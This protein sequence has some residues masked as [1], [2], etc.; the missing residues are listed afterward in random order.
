[1]LGLVAFAGWA[2]DIRSL[3]SIVP[4]LDPMVATSSLCAAIAALGFGSLNGNLPVRSPAASV[5]GAVIVVLCVLTITEYAVGHSLGIDEMI[6]AD[7]VAAIRPFPGSMTIGAALAFNA[8]G[9]ALLLLGLSVRPR[10]TQLAHG[11]AIVPVAVALLSLAGH[12]QGAGGLYRVG[13]FGIVSL[14]TALALTAL[15]AALLMTRARQGWLAAYEGRPMARS[16]LL[17]ILA[18]SMAAP[19]ATGVFVRFGTRDLPGDNL[20]SP[21]LFSIAVTALF[22]GLALRAASAVRD[23][24]GAIRD[25]AA[26]AARAA[27]LLRAVVANVGGAV[28]AKD[29]DGRYLVV[30][31]AGCRA[32]G[33]TRDEM[34][35]STDAELFPPDR[36]A[37]RRASDMIALQGT[38][39]FTLEETLMVEGQTRIYEVTKSVFR[40]ASGAIAG[41]VGVA[42]DITGRREAERRDAFLL[43]L[44]DRLRPLA[45]ANAIRQTAVEALAAEIDVGRVSY[46]E[47]DEAQNMCR[48]EWTFSAHAMPVVS[49]NYSLEGLEQVMGA[50]KAGHQ[51]IVADNWQDP[52]LAAYV[53]RPDIAAAQV[54]ALLNTP[55]IK[56]GLLV[57]ALTIHHPEPR[58]WTAWEA[59]LAR[60]VADRTWAASERA[61]A[62]AALRTSEALVRERADEIAAIYDSAPVGLCVLD[63]NLRFVRINDHL[64]NLNGVPAADHIGKTFGEVLP[65]LKGKVLEMAQRVLAGEIIEDFELSGM[66]PAHPGMTRTWRE[67]WLPLRDGAGE[68]IGITVSAEDVTEAKARALRQSLL[69]DLADRLRASPRDALASASALVGGWLGASRVG[70]A[71]A[72]HG[73]EAIALVGGFTDGI[74]NPGTALRRFD[75]FSPEV[76]AEIVAGH[77]LIVGDIA[78]DPRTA[79]MI[80]AETV[81]NAGSAVAVPLVR[82]G[83]VRASFYVYYREARSWTDEE[84]GLI[85]EIAA[86]SWAVAEQSR[87][88]L[89]LRRTRRRLDAVLNNASVAIFLTDDRQHCTYMNHAAEELTGYALAET[90]GRPLHEVV[91]HHH[92]DGRPYPIEDCPIERAFPES[93]NTRGEDVFVHKNGRF[94]PVGFVASPIRDEAARIVGTII[95]VRDI[96]AERAAQTALVALNADLELRVADALAEQRMLA[97]IVESTDVILSAIDLEFN[98][99]ARNRAYLE[100]FSRVWGIRP[101]V[102][103]NLIDLLADH[104][105]DQELV[106]TLWQR[107]LGG[108]EFTVID[109][110]GDAALHRGAYELTFRCLRD[111]HGAVAGIYQ[112][113]R[114]ISERLQAQAEL[115]TARAQLH[116][117]QKLETIGQLTGSVAHDFNNLL[118]PIFGGLDFVRR[119]V[120]G[121]ERVDRAVDGAL[122]SAE[123]ARDLIQR[124]LAFARRQTLQPRSVDVAA[125]VDGMRDLIDRSIGRNIQVRVDMPAG[126]PFAL[127]DPNQLEMAL[128][129]LCINARDAMPGGGELE[130]AAAETVAP[131][132]LP[133]GHYVRLSVTDT[134]TGMDAETLSRAVE[135]FFSTKGEGQGTGLGLS[136]VHGLAA[137]SGGLFQLSSAPGTGTI[138]ALWLP[139]SKRAAET[140]IAEGHSEP[141]RALWRACVLLV[142][143]EELVRLSTAE[144][145]RDMGYDVAEAGSADEALAKVRAGFKPEALITDH[146]MPGMS[147]VELAAQLRTTLPN[148]PVLL[149][150]GYCNLQPDE[151]DGLHVLAKP[152]RHADLLLHVARIL[153]E[154]EVVR[155][156]PKSRLGPSV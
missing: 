91:H 140:I 59:E 95:E 44:E 156:R 138:A 14:G 132:S 21:A 61:R 77:T 71:I 67:N 22:A 69:L 93:A 104:P 74:A 105:E 43:A 2:L 130:I 92:P 8:L 99:I 4:G 68:I 137:Q 107:A 88:E 76:V 143:D 46:L 75:H 102:G 135:P 19:I 142:D 152:F 144:D 38:T 6:V 37:T 53:A 125:L 94:Y 3:T 45:D 124:L 86:R 89:E 134:G 50:M 56:D 117:M 25:N 80:A 48:V 115:E 154:G 87:A 11:F 26:E 30:N 28:F 13:T 70:Y 35:G 41:I 113:A 112:F 145:L 139:V 63:T 146:M 131:Q 31:D 33:K 141:P 110:F 58:E 81:G 29:P 148:L 149:I 78:N 111:E 34:L 72:A 57:G 62:E 128:L 109:E 39:P 120:T 119:R 24:E 27:E 129:N 103:D 114:D 84:I 18:L 126:L 16:A 1:M 79:A 121:D 122:F 153:Q 147:G 9:T 52:R 116:E 85:E 151:T 108:E 60:A 17:H 64:A 82:N 66:T 98:I 118:T 100:A 90:Q 73:G 83:H 150:T 106:R 12:A 32:N 5:C 101:K 127:A 36:A 23:G 65:D 20:L 42:I 15:S 47:I 136:M 10:W 7:T 54:R 97:E 55:L 51:L 155:R 96:A 49:G 40:D 133:A 123:R